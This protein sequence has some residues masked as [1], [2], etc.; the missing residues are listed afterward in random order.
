[1]SELFVYDKVFKLTP[2]WHSTEIVQKNYRTTLPAKNLSFL[3]L[4]VAPREKYYNKI[5]FKSQKTKS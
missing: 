4:K 2:L 5:L 1:M 3:N